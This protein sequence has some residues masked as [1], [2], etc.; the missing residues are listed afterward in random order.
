MPSQTISLEIMGLIFPLCVGEK[1][2]KRFY[3]CFASP[4]AKPLDCLMSSKINSN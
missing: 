3:N 1:H 2:S 4:V